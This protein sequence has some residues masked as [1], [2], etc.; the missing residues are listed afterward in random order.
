M[1]GQDD[2][3]ALGLGTDGLGHVTGNLE[4]ERRRGDVER[5]DVLDRRLDRDELG[6]E[7]HGGQ[8]LL[9]AIPEGIEVIRHGQAALDLSRI[10]CRT[11]QAGD[12][13]DLGL[14]VGAINGAHLD[15]A[16]FVQRTSGHGLT[17]DK[18]ADALLIRGQS[19]LEDG[20]FDDARGGLAAIGHRQIEDDL[21]T[22]TV[23]RVWSLGPRRN[24]DGR[25]RHRLLGGLGDEGLP[26]QRRDEGEQSGHIIA[27]TPPHSLV[28]TPAQ[29]KP[30]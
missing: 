2:W 29:H 18:I 6:L 30:V 10:D 13:G 25:I 19:I 12:R 21:L 28:N 8:F 20:P 1:H 7:W 26:Q 22:L 17:V 24:L 5:F 14:G 9:H 23:N 15:E 27:M 11:A 3:Q 4:A 16:R